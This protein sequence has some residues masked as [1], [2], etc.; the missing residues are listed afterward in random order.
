MKPQ[1]FGPGQKESNWP[2]SM[3]QPSPPSTGQG[4]RGAWHCSSKWK[5]SVTPNFIPQTHT[6]SRKITD[7][8]VKEKNLTTFRKKPRRISFWPWL[9][10]RKYT[11]WQKW[12]R[13][14]RCIK[15]ENFCTKRHQKQNLMK[16][17]R[18]RELPMGIPCAI[19]YTRE[20]Q[21]SP[22]I[23]MYRNVCYSIFSNCKKKK[24]QCKC[25]SI[26]E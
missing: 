15:M 10:F 2:Y 1:R 5:Y 18:L 26:G 9:T 4:G 13:E 11:K 25:L 24:W 6:L 8:R 14:K 22:Q 21:T 19:L 20:T 17:H 12:W 3:W 16:S 7:I 23:F